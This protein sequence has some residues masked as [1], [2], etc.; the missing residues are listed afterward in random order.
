MIYKIY[1]NNPD[2]VVRDDATSIPIAE[3]FLSRFDN[4]DFQEYQKWLDAGNEPEYITVV[5]KPEAEQVLALPLRI[6]ALEQALVD[7][8]I[9][10]K[11]ANI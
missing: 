8:K 11:K 9:R 4:S 5:E 3:K 7:L 10:L 2:M 1:S 6:A